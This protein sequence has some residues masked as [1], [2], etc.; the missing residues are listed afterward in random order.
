MVGELRRAVERG[1]LAPGQ[2]LPAEPALAAEFGVS[3]SSLREALKALQLS[4]YLEVRRGYGGGTFV[5]LPEAEEFMVVPAPAVPTLAVSARQLMDVRL[6]I[7]PH[8]A[9]LAV[10]AN[11]ERRLALQAAEAEGAAVDDHPARALAAIVKFHIA[12]AQAA[13]NPVFVIILEG[14]RPLMYRSMNALVQRAG[15]R[16]DCFQDHADILHHIEAG[17]GEAAAAAMRG[18][19]AME[20]SLG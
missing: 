7:E 12:V 20:A 6:A 4:G 14:L 1:E 19:L 2:K 5:A 8:A 11:L 10:T 16:T 9:S 3:R 13:E 17:D 18:H 15:W